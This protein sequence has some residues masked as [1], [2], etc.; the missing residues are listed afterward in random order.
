MADA[1]VAR[2]GGETAWAEGHRQLESYESDRDLSRFRPALV[3]DAKDARHFPRL[4]AFE[5]WTA[6]L[7]YGSLRVLESFIPIFRSFFGHYGGS[8]R[9][10]N[11]CANQFLLRIL[12]FGIY[13]ESLHFLYFT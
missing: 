5:D 4:A 10:F 2:E 8:I 11:A 13:V 6:A 1:A 7:V 3:V 9:L 12:V